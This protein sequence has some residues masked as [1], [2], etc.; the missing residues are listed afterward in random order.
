VLVPRRD[1]R[2]DPALGRHSHLGGVELNLRGSTYRGGNP[3][4]EPLEGMDFGLRR[5]LCHADSTSL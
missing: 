3:I 5:G 1:V 2:L 4:D